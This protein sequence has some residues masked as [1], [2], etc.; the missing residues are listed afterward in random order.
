MNAKNENETIDFEVNLKGSEGEIA[1]AS[2]SE[3]KIKLFN[4][5]KPEGNYSINMEIT[6][7]KF[8]LY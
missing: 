5:D 3:K 6:Y 1:A 8:I 7:D 2:E 4:I